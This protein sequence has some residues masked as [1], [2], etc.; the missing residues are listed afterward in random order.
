MSLFLISY[1][2]KYYTYHKN[3]SSLT[4]YRN[5]VDVQESGTTKPFGSVLSR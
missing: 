4:L 3:T 5:Y 2:Q 1:L